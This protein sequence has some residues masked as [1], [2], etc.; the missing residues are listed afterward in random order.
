MRWIWGGVLTLVL[1]SACRSNDV[2]A[3]PEGPGL[4]STDVLDDDTY[5]SASPK[6][7]RVPVLPAAN[8]VSAKS[9]RVHVTAKGDT[10]MNLA[11]LY[12]SSA[13]RWRDIFDA[14]RDQ[15]SDPNRILVG[16]VLRIP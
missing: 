3:I 16:Q 11:R 6:D 4:T 10:L 13:S 12:Y 8:S 9:E 14:N 1:V 5:V 7:D 2:D 15:I